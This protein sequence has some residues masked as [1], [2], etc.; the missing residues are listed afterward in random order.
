[1]WCCLQPQREAKPEPQPALSPCRGNPF[2]V[3]A[4]LFMACPETLLA[5]SPAEQRVLELL[6]QG[7]SNRCI[8][9]RLR[10]SPR[11][12]ESHVTTMLEKTG[13]RSRTQL[14]L[15]Q[16]NR[17][18]RGSLHPGAR[19]DC[20]DAGSSSTLGVPGDPAQHRTTGG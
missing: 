12:V 6:L 5:I 8:A 4:P 13:C 16:L 7:G 19:Q 14:V 1:M 9:L 2:R 18:N 20:A 15:W 10:L 11:T 17:L 3:F